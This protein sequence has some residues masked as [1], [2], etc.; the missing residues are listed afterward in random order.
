MNDHGYDEGGAFHLG[1]L[2][3]ELARHGLKPAAP[4]TQPPPTTVRD[5][6]SGPPSPD[7]VSAVIAAMSRAMYPAPTC[8]ITSTADDAITI[9]ASVSASAPHHDY[10]GYAADLTLIDQLSTRWGS[11]GESFGLRELWAVVER[12][13]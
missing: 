5:R 3:Q 1:V 4:V 12:R 2:Q 6:T 9:T 13:A 10:P 8:I 7:A 11:R